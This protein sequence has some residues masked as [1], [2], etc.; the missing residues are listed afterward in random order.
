MYVCCI[1]KRKLQ[2]TFKTD[3]HK[4]VCQKEEKNKK[5]IGS[6]NYCN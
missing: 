6:N 2:Y 1:Y 3:M 4:H 5:T